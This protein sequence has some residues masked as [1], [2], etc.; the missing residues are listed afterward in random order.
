LP[1]PAVQLRVHNHKYKRLLYKNAAGQY[2]AATTT[3]DLCYQTPQS[4]GL[5]ITGAN[6]DLVTSIDNSISG[7]LSAL[8][9][10]ITATNTDVQQA[11]D[12]IKSQACTS[13]C[14]PVC[15]VPATC[16]QS[17]SAPYTGTYCSSD[18]LS[19]YITTYLK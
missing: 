1:S 7:S 17:C 6:Q 16:P 19:N 14:L 10:A 8:N 18:D 11:I 4:S 12:D 15:G 5:P 2:W 3:S 13:P 9:S